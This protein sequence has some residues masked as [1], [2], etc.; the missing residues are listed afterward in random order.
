VERDPLS[1][2]ELLAN[3]MAR[4]AN[5]MELE[6]MGIRYLTRKWSKHPTLF[7]L[8]WEM[9]FGR[10]KTDLGVWNEMDK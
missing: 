8:D 9:N 1:D 4:N 2:Q 6:V 5:R 7:E 10:R 3:F